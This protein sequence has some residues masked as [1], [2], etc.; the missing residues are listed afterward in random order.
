MNKQILLPILFFTLIFQLHAGTNI[1]TTIHPEWK[2]EW[3]TESSLIISWEP[4]INENINIYLVQRIGTLKLYIAN[5][6]DTKTLPTPNKFSWEIPPA[7]PGDKYYIKIVDMN[8]NQIS[9]SR[10]FI[11]KPRSIPKKRVGRRVLTQKKDIRKTSPRFIRVTSPARDAVLFNNRSYVIK[12]ETKI[13]ESLKLHL[14]RAR[15]KRLIAPILSNTNKSNLLRR[16]Q[17]NWKVPNHID[18]GEYI[19]RIGPLSSIEWNYSKKFRIMKSP[20]GTK[21]NFRK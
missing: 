14:C 16:N 18:S 4:L 8:E 12:W 6:L 2:Q 21:K 13:N 1:E 5:E 3:L 10:Q 15:D 7:I 11:I 17:Y 20:A 9:S 19:I